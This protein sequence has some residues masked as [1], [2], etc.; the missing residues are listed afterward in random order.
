MTGKSDHRKALEA[1]AEKVGL[2][3]PW[4]LGDTKLEKRVI[5][6]EAAAAQPNPA[7]PPTEDVEGF[8]V[9]GP[10]RG[11]RRAGRFFT[12]EPVHIPA[13]ELSSGD[14]AALEGDPLLT[15]TYTELAADG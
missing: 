5:A 2:E 1:R 8:V 4:N 9:T 10:R 3:Y 14:L 6:A 11:R 15:V 7:T 12:D 13:D